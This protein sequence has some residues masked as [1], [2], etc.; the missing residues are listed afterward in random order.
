IAMREQYGDGATTAAA[1][2]GTLVDGLQAL[3]DSGS[4][5]GQLDAEVGACTAWLARGLSSGSGPRPVTGNE[6]PAPSPDEL[7]A[8]VRTALGRHEKAEA[9][10]TA[11]I[12]VGAGNVEVVPA[13]AGGTETQ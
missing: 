11:A 2:L 3:L 12:V 8:A 9:V 1:I 6:P 7:R 4:E 10:V 5:P 13:S